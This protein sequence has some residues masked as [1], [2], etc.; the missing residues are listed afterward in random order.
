MVVGGYDMPYFALCSIAIY[1][2][3]TLMHPAEVE[4]CNEAATLALTVLTCCRL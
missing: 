1:V 3:Q 4:N 2:Q